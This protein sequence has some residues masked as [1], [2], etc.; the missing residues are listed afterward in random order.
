MCS[1]GTP[2]EITIF[3]LNVLYTKITITKLGTDFN[4][5]TSIREDSEKSARYARHRTW[6]QPRVANIFHLFESLWMSI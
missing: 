1:L 5:R 2:L 6:F 4:I 3:L